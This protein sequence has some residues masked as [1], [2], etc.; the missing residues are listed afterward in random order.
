MRKARNKKFSLVMALVFAFT[1]IFPAGAA[2]AA[3]EAKFSSSYNYI[4]ADDEQNAG[5]VT[6]KPDSDADGS[7]Q[8]TVYVT[9]TL[10]E[11]VEFTSRPKSTA[12]LDGGLL[13]TSYSTGDYGFVSSGSTFVKVW[14]AG[15]TWDDGS[16]DYVTFDFAEIDDY[17]K[18]KLDIDKDFTGNLQVT[19]E[20]QGVKGTAIVWTLDDDL[21]IAKV[22][23]GDITIKAGSTKK[24]SAG[25]DKKV[26]KITVEESKSGVI[27]VG[28]SVTLTIETDDVEFS[29][30]ST[31][32]ITAVG[33]DGITVGAVSVEKDG[34]DNY[35]IAKVTVTGKSAT[36][37]GTITFDPIGLDIAPSVNEDIEITVEV[38]DPDEDETLTVATVGDVTMEVQDL[39]DNDGVVYAGQDEELDVEFTLATTDGSDFTEG[40]II[41]LT[42][43]QGEFAEVPDVDGGTVKRYDDD[44]AFYITCSGGGDEIDVSELHVKLKNDAEPG[45]ITLT[46][47][48]DYGDLEEFV[49]ATSAKPY[50]VTADKPNIP[51]EALGAAAGDLTIT[52]TAGGALKKGE[53]I[54]I[55]LPSGVELSGK[56]KIDV[57]EGGGD[58]KID[59]YDDDFFVIEITEE[60]S[61][62]KP[63]TFLVSNIKYDT[64][65]LAMAGEVEL[66]FFG[67]DVEEGT[68]KD[69]DYDDDSMMTTVVN[70]TVKDGS[71]VTATFKV[72][73]EGV[74]IKNGRTLV[75]VNML[76]DVLGLQKSWDE[77]S[78]TAYFVK[79]GK[80]V[81]FPMGENAIYINGVKLPQDQGGVIINNF[82]YATLRG[83]QAAFGGELTWDDTTKTAT[84]DF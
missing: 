25:G 55:E 67:D 17:S 31:N 57:T 32:S 29:R 53:E 9:L 37:P 48:G 1:V 3:D 69:N 75:Q 44:E 59:Q 40:D 63:T 64:G 79:D 22:A 19:V 74:T 70:A 52:E 33:E 43:N 38:S 66:K 28:E 50:T 35:T 41:T 12:D 76:C 80:V 4:S 15:A 13:D 56:P 58:A 62:S 84:F 72:G 11:G 77:A 65:K 34:D 82:T 6:V 8:D 36:F 20:V 30:S 81:A 18:N 27:D 5:T 47:E 2:F 60:S 46:I 49:I 7:V 51:T 78:K 54:Y 39:E 26:A 83:I 42:L 24:V 16:A 71:A 21:T 61:S 73:D 23:E 68:D 10:P 45:D 14:V